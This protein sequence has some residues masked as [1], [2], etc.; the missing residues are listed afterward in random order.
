[1]VW[2]L[3]AAGT[4]VTAS[5]L[6]HS[7]DKVK[8]IPLDAGG[9]CGCLSVFRDKIGQGIESIGIDSELDKST[10]TILGECI[11]CGL[12]KKG[13]PKEGL[14]SCKRLLLNTF[15]WQYATPV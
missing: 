3:F 2:L 5:V 6:P 12:K 15:A 9:C 1:M 8:D 7:Q 10:D 11:I 14:I 13:E 4:V